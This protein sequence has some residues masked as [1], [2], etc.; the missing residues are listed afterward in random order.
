MTEALNFAFN[1]K[2]FK[3]FP[4]LR[5]AFVLY[6][7]GRQPL[8]KYE[9][10]SISASPT[11]IA[12][13]PADTLENYLA[14]KT[15][16]CRNKVQAHSRA[17][18]RRNRRIKAEGGVFDQRGSCGLG[19]T[20]KGFQMRRGSSGVNEAALYAGSIPLYARC[21][22]E[23]KLPICGEGE[24]GNS[25]NLLEDCAANCAGFVSAWKGMEMSGAALA[26]NFCRNLSMRKV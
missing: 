7:I 23:P 6:G 16:V 21:K 4:V 13:S 15:V 12:Q 9:G 17:V 22:R 2:L 1:G 3:H 10:A 26:A 19:L 24:L 18:S 20:V 11:E 5:P 25:E 14:L 8:S